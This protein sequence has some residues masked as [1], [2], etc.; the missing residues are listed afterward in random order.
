MTSSPTK[1]SKHIVITGDHFYIEGSGSCSPPKIPPYLPYT[2]SKS[3]RS[4]KHQKSLQWLSCAR[5]DVGVGRANTESSRW[6]LGTTECFCLQ[7][8]DTDH[9][10]QPLA[11]E[12]T[13]RV[14]PGLARWEVT[15]W[16]RH[17]NTW[18]ETAP[19]PLR[20]VVTSVIPRRQF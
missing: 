9:A 20:F 2:G 4:Y 12:D 18:A 15:V 13:E 8:G 16:G 3:A 17:R 1:L 14:V 11:P 10:E 7:A 19:R 6:A 5:H